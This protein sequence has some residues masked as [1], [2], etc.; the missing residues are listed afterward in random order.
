MFCGENMTKIDKSTDRRKEDRITPE[1]GMFCKL[2]L[3][4]VQDATTFLGSF[5]ISNLSLLGLGI[6]LGEKKI[7]QVGNEKL[8]QVGSVVN[9]SFEL[10]TEKIFFEAH[11][12][13]MSEKFIGLEYANLTPE[14]F[15]KMKR[16]LSP[17][18]VAQSIYSISKESLDAKIYAAFR[19]LDFEC[20]VFA[21]NAN[22]LQPEDGLISKLHFVI[23]GKLVELT[24][25]GARILNKDQLQPYQKNF[26]SV[27]S[28]S[29]SFS[30]GERS[31]SKEL[32][33]SIEKIVAVL[34]LWKPKDE[35]L[36]S[37]IIGFVNIASAQNH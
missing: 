20:I 15:I 26:D 28:F 4:K 36:A 6:N 14:F 37:K 2:W 19:G 7:H 22:L 9:G 17:S 5:D 16:A 30:H 24:S 34:K 31:D 13:V 33:E 23:N 1:I 10:M 3:N 12:R 8:L 11:I 25:A 18:V 29:A 32:T 35:S 21:E 27:H